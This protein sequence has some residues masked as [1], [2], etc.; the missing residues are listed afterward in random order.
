MRPMKTANVTLDNEIE[1]LDRARRLDEQAL[2][3]IYQTYH[4]A[5]YRYIYYHVG[6]V[7]TAQDLTSEVFRRFLLAMHGGSG[8]DKLLKAW[9]YRVAHNLI[10]DEFRSNRYRNHH[11][12]D[13]DTD[14]LL[15]DDEASPEH[16]AFQT[17]DQITLRAMLSELTEEQRQVII[18][19][20]LEEMSN[21]EIAQITG[22]TIGAVKALQYRG[23]EE[24]R[25]KLLKTSSRHFSRY[26]HVAQHA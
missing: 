8:P 20:F 23:L 10:I 17:M 25:Q 4:D 12:L 3:H 5:I 7:E 16:Q 13:Q 21:E 15:P 22:R 9:L 18:L 24:L 14:D 19:K 2:T 1:L 26:Q 6:H 11:S